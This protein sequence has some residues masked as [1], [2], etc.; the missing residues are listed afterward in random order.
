M[1]YPG[2]DEDVV[3]TRDAQSKQVCYGRLDGTKV[4]AHLVPTPSPKATQLSKLDWP[5]MRLQ[6]HRLPGKGNIIRVLD[7]TGKDF[8]NVDVKTSTGLARIMDSKNP[9]IRTQARL[10]LR[11]K[12]PYE[13]P[14]SECSKYLDMTI[15]LYGPKDKAESV[16]R[17]LSQKQLYLRAPFGVDSGIEVFN[18][19]SPNVLPRTSLPGMS[20]GIVPN[21]SYVSRTV[22]EIRS[23]VV[24]MFDSLEKSEHLPEMEPDS[25]ITTPLL[26]HQYVVASQ[27][28][29]QSVDR[30]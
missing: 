19:H 6:L 26:S 20:A 1:I 15:N 24:G 14:G 18:P 7:P 21:V 16:G 17:F 13:T 25:R 23:D 2:D 8:G 11:K 4:L 10:N 12:E 29:H 3:M 9:K 27:W 5:P 28:W 22:E 30:F